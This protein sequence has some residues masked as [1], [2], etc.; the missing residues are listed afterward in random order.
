MSVITAGTEG[1]SN[2]KWGLWGSKPVQS[3]RVRDRTL[4]CHSA[5]AWSLQVIKKILGPSVLRQNSSGWEAVDLLA[6]RHLSEREKKNKG[7]CVWGTLATE[8]EVMLCDAAPHYASPENQGKNCRMQATNN[9]KTRNS[10]HWAPLAQAHMR[11]LTGLRAALCG[12][13]S[14]WCQTLFTRYFQI[15][16][17]LQGQSSRVNTHQ[18]DIWSNWK[19][20]HRKCS[21]RPHCFILGCWRGGAAA[22]Q[23]RTAFSHYCHSEPLP[24]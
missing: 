18:C 21:Q 14:N 2:K 16:W 20:G 9:A 6:L 12:G 22:Q 19:Q 24:L 23:H 5:L 8:R 11:V 1:D 4:C 3:R 7:E 13:G 15:K 10:E 17:H